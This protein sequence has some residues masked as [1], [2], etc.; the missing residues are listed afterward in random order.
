[1]QYRYILSQA[2][3][4]TMATRILLVAI[5]IFKIQYLYQYTLAAVFSIRVEFIYVHKCYLCWF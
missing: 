4:K 2:V 3:R 5:E 1:M